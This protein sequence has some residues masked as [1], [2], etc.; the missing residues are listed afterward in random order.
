MH[1]PEY[2][3]FDPAYL[4]LYGYNDGTIL[5]DQEVTN[6]SIYELTNKADKLLYVRL[7]FNNN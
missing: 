7:G 5:S 3:D 1:E 6:L 4:E 2:P